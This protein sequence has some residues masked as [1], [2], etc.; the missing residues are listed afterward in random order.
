M[1]V[2]EGQSYAVKVI[3]K[4]A[5]H[6]ETE[7]MRVMH[8]IEILR[9]VRHEGCVKLYDAFQCEKSVYLVLEYVPVCLSVSGSVSF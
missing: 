3:D 1:H 7:R 5:L 6:G 8:E 9:W 4:K 2:E